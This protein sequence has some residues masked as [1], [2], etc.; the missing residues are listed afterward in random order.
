MSFVFLRLVSVHQVLK[1]NIILKN[2]IMKFNTNNYKSSTNKALVLYIQ[3]FVAFCR[4]IALFP[5]A[6]CPRAFCLSGI[7]S[8]GI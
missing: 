8:G 4:S 6:F 2:N 7:F 1:L 3:S 5:V